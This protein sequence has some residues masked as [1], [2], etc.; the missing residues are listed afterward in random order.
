MWLVA[1]VIGLCSPD[2]VFQHL[3]AFELYVRTLSACILSGLK[4][5]S[6]SKGSHKNEG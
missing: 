1:P 6:A 2:S 4:A 3:S 5:K